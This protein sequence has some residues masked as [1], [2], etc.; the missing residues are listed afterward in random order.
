MSS[1]TQKPINKS[2]VQ[3]LGPLE[4][5]EDPIENP[6]FSPPP[7]IEGLLQAIVGDT[8]RDVVP[9]ALQQTGLVLQIRPWER[10][11]FN[12]FEPL[13]VLVNDRPEFITSFETSVNLPDPVVIN[14][15][16]RD[17]LKENGL[18]DIRVVVVYASE[19]VIN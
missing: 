19:N 4:D 8:H 15:G 2:S 9:R 1:N 18:K 5:W 10:G 14:L 16:P 13:T 7:I 17:A 12:A 6:S 11:L 3:E